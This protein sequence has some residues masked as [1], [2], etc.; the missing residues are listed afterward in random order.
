MANSSAVAVSALSPPLSR[1]MLWSCLPGGLATISMP[2][3]SGS[4]FVE[5]DQVGFAA[6]EQ[7][8]VHHLEIL[9]DLLEGL[10]EQLLR[11]DIDLRDDLQEL[12]LGLDQVFVLLR[13]GTCSAPPIPRIR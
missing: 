13:R 10:L 12:V 8:G 7:L 11:G 5:Q 9:A 1:V 3:S 2:L 6:A 4:S